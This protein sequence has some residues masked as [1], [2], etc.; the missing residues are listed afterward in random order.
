[1]STN[2]I[3]VSTNISNLTSDK[4]GDVEIHIIENLHRG[5]QV[6]IT[7][8]NVVVRTHVPSDVVIEVIGGNL[9]IDG[10]VSDNVKI[11]ASIDPLV[12]TLSDSIS[13]EEAPSQKD[14]LQLKDPV[15][16]TGS[17]SPKTNIKADG[18]VQIK[19]GCVEVTGSISP[20]TNINADGGVQIQGR[21]M[22]VEGVTRK[23][24]EKLS[25]VFESMLENNDYYSNLFLF[26]QA[27]LVV[28]PNYCHQFQTDT[29][30]TE[31]HELS[32]TTTI[33][34]PPLL[35]RAAADG[36]KEYLEALIIAGDD[37]NVEHDGKNA[38]YYA[39]EGGHFECA[40]LLIQAKE[41][42]SSDNVNG[43]L[44][45]DRKLAKETSFI[46]KPEQLQTLISKAKENGEI[47]SLKLFSTKHARH[48]HQNSTIAELE[49]LFDHETENLKGNDVVDDD[50]DET[51]GNAGGTET[52]FFDSHFDMEVAT[53]S[54][55]LT[56]N[57]SND[58]SNV[59]SNPLSDKKNASEKENSATLGDKTTENPLGGRYRDTMLRFKVA[60]QKKNP[61]Q[62]DCLNFS[63][64]D[65][66]KDNIKNTE[67]GTD[68]EVDKD[69]VK[70]YGSKF[71]R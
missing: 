59:S 2:P 52:S 26:N 68:D 42:R 69:S 62:N 51:L 66:V 4:K 12:Q 57:F 1:M 38:F 37:I 28:G 64:N 11:T 35:I 23:Y 44:N 46:L 50:S 48:F 9:K 63:E 10:N 17:I 53:R 58:S 55:S 71:S 67:A 18:G 27:R 19:E 3:Q 47:E 15:E 21:L 70:S 43:N 54:R 8:K 24:F 25:E 16:V 6:K 49:Y 34:E 33:S 22:I 60:L 30:A 45:A 39:L 56:Y 7:G 5:Q 29:L 13:T 65:K 61:V 31:S 41:N 36:F 32:Q 20:K 40:A 14:T